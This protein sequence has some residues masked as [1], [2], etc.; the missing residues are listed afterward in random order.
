MTRSTASEDHVDS[1][2]LQ[3]HLA[4]R[5]PALLAAVLDAAHVANDGLSEGSEALADRLVGALWWRTH[6]PVGQVAAPD[7]L[8]QLVDRVGKKLTVSLPSGDTWT[9]LAALTDAVVPTNRPVSLH[10]LDDRTVRKLRRGAW[11][12]LFGWSGVGASAASRWAAVRTL[13]LLKGPLYNLLVMLPRV[14]PVLVKVKGAAGAVAAVSGPVGIALAL[15]SLNA[16]LGPRYDK[17][18]PLLVGVGLVMRNPVA[19]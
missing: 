8:G 2:A 9:R 4:R 18:L 16:S 1:V 19:V 3:A 5:D 10:S 7:D 14:G 13:G 17:A 11:A 12:Q 15:A 6:T